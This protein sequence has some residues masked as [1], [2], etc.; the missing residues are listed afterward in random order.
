MRFW[1][2][3]EKDGESA[4]WKYSGVYEIAIEDD[5]TKEYAKELAKKFA[6]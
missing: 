3:R 1:K 5:M 6:R 2:K 4:M